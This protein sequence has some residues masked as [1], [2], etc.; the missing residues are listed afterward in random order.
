[1]GSINLQGAGPDVSVY[2]E[3]RAAQERKHLIVREDA[4]VNVPVLDV[5]LAMWGICHAVD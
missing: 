1:M 3:M 4:E 5:D 2:I